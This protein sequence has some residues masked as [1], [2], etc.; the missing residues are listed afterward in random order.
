[1]MLKAEN[2]NKKGLNGKA[3]FNKLFSAIYSKKKYLITQSCQ[4]I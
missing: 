4:R 3:F 2:S 1:M